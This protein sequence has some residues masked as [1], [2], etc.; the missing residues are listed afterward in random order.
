MW[1]DGMSREAVLEHYGYDD[2][3]EA[4]VAMGFWK[5]ESV[6]EQIGKL[7]D[8]LTETLDFE[9]KV[10]V[11]FEYDPD[12]ARAYLRVEGTKEVNMK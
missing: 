8:A 10:R 2:T 1:E 9:K 3:D 12:F 7:S 5:K 6:P 11:I 4:H